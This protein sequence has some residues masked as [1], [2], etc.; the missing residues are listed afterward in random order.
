M[1]NEITTRS[2]ARAG[3][4]AAILVRMRDRLKRDAEFSEPGFTDSRRHRA[5]A[6]LLRELIVEIE[7]LEDVA[8]ATRE[9]GT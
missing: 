7:S 5:R 3:M 2:P 8:S 4:K 9:A 6:E 1:A